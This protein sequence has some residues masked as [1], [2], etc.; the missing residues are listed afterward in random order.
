MSRALDINY[1]KS[2]ANFIFINRCTVVSFFHLVT[3]LLSFV[4][5]LLTKLCHTDLALF[6]SIRILLQALKVKVI[7]ISL[8]LTN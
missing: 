3:L 5:V 4:I 7:F 2:Q 6:Q 8:C 1:R